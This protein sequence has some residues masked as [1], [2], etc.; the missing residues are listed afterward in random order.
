MNSLGGGNQSPLRLASVNGHLA[1][2]QVLLDHG[3]DV[4]LKHEDGRSALKCAREESHE[5]I[6]QL[7]LKHGADPD[8]SAVDDALPVRTSPKLLNL[9]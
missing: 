6:V 5:A 1:I 3:A 4:N 9:S 8:E 2:A 7:L